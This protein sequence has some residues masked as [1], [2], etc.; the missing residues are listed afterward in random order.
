MIDNT[1]A[2]LLNQVCFHILACSDVDRDSLALAMAMAAMRSLVLRSG[3]VRSRSAIAGL[4][5][6]VPVWGARGCGRSRI[7]SIAQWKG[8]E[9]LSMHLLG[10]DR[11]RASS[12]TLESRFV[13]GC[14]Y[15]QIIT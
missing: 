7:L 5:Y 6:V 2:W 14:K 9:A 10:I 1:R 12:S 13:S 11:A 8:F 4:R 3:I 15:V